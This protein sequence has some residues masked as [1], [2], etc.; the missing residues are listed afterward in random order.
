MA[1]KRK[2]RGVAAAALKNVVTKTSSKLATKEAMA[3]LTSP[4]PVSPSKATKGK[5]DLTSKE[6]LTTNL[7]S[8]EDK[9]DSIISQTEKIISEET[10]KPQ[11][12]ITAASCRRK[13]AKPQ[14]KNGESFS[15]VYFKMSITHSCTNIS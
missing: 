15:N 14:R 11:S 3:S 2:R 7:A 1:R 4:L 10:S 13:Q 8:K 9:L 12:P 5:L 6:S